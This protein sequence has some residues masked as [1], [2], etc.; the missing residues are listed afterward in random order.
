MSS[1]IMFGAEEIQERGNC[2]TKSLAVKYHT[3]D[4]HWKEK[5]VEPIKKIYFKWLHKKMNKVC[6]N[7][8]NKL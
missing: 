1:L 4:T 8:D 2:L 5:V 3:Q 7:Q 6:S